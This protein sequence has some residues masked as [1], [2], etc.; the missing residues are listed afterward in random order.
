MYSIKDLQETVH[1]RTR[2]SIYFLWAAEGWSKRSS[3]ATKCV[4][5][6]FFRA[7]F[8]HREH[9]SRQGTTLYC[10]YSSQT[11]WSFKQQ[12][13]KTRT[14]GEQIVL[15]VSPCSDP[16]QRKQANK[17]SHQRGAVYLSWGCNWLGVNFQ[18]IFQAVF[19]TSAGGQVCQTHF[20]YLCLLC[21]LAALLVRLRASSSPWFVSW[22]PLAFCLYLFITRIFKGMSRKDGV[23]LTIDFSVN[24]GRKMYVCAQRNTRRL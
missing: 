13:W 3:Q 12:D 18:N 23:R 16:V 22:P 19:S 9:R 5:L 7:I 20:L 10:N 15:R 11:S 4:T 8:G 14:H 24:S 6:A 2:G 17:L 21:P 1:I